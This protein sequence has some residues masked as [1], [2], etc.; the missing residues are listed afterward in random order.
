M[1][2]LPA[3][4]PYGNLVPGPVYC[5]STLTQWLNFNNQRLVPMDG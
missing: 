2:R 5:S 3:R 1:H 4:H